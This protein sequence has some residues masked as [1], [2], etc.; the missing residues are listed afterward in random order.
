V[1]SLRKKLLKK[2]ASKT[3]KAPPVDLTG[4]AF[5]YS[6]E[7]ALLL[8]QEMIVSST[9]SMTQGLFNFF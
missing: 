2:V 1:Y 6:L 7:F 9:L 8:A 4:G 5:S 3:Q